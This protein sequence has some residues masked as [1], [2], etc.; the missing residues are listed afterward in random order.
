MIVVELCNKKK[1]DLQVEYTNAIFCNVTIKAKGYFSRLSSFALYGDIPI[2]YTNGLQTATCVEAVWHG[3][4]CFENEG[5]DYSTFK[6]IL[7]KDIIRS[8][9]THGKL[10]GFQRGYVDNGYLLNCLEAR[11]NIYF[12]TY[13]WMLENKAFDIV[14]QLRNMSRNR[15]IVLLDDIINN[16][17]DD[18]NKPLSIAYLVKAYAEGLYPYED[19]Y[20][21]RE[22]HKYVF[23][24]RHDV[25]IMK[26]EKVLRPINKDSIKKE[27]ELP[28]DLF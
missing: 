6:S 5:A 22:T 16:N 19:V 17:P 1:E 28:I 25:D 7:L 10:I 24:G 13:R 26:T 4:K 21:Y 2:P 15:T 27:L 12:P 8:T 14:E 20:E 23:V 3:L 9:K 11:K 18:I